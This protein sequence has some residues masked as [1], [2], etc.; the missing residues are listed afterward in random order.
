M[1]LEKTRL[2]GFFLP[3]KTVLGGIAKGLHIGATFSSF[4]KSAMG[5][6]CVHPLSTGSAWGHG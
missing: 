5:L 1:V 6:I 2:G 4:A 3:V